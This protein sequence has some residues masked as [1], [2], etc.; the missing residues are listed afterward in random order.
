MGEERWRK[1]EILAAKIK[2]FLSVSLHAV[3]VSVC[4]VV[5]Y[6]THLSLLLCIFP[7]EVYIYLALKL[8]TAPSRRPDILSFTKQGWENLQIK[9]FVQLLIKQKFIMLPGQVRGGGGG[10]SPFS[11]LLRRSSS[12]FIL[13]LCGQYL[14]FLMILFL[15]KT[16]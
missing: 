6:S 10:V 16:N 14:F 15:N 2:K 7:Y 5:G 9:L 8:F 3:R 13:S 11:S 4:R 1:D 12:D